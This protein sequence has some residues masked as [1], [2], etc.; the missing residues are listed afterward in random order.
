MERQVEHARAVQVQADA[1]LAG[2][3]ADAGELVEI[4]HFVVAPPHR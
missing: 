2:Q 3:A 4:D 1:A